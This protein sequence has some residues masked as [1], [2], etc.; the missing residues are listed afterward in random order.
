MTSRPIGR[1]HAEA[2]PEGGPSAVER[3]ESLLVAVAIVQGIVLGAWLGLLPDSA[4]RA[5]GFPPSG[6][7][8]V[9]WAGVLHLVL[10]TGYVLEWVRFRRTAL[11]V[12]AKAA[13]AA[14]LALVWIADGLPRLL[15]L[16]IVLEAALATAAALLHGP[17]ERS[18]RASARLRLVGSSSNEVRPAGR[19]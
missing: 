8:F 15:V 9:R 11:L 13:T 10:A 4:L 12:V 17:A 6:A 7:F 1:I 14:F 18:R 3:A 2:S 19:T 5:G 16:A